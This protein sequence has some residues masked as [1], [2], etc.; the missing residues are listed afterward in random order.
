MYK[1]EY[2]CVLVLLCFRIV[3][4]F[5]RTL[6]WYEKESASASVTRCI[7]AAILCL[8]QSGI[9]VKQMHK[10]ATKAF[11][12]IDLEAKHSSR[13]VDV[14]HEPEFNAF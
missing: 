3:K 14:V 6:F 1:Y 2:K 10:K 11:C 7:V 5:V 12:R 9:K 13:H 4:T 8:Q